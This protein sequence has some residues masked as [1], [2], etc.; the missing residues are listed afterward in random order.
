LFAGPVLSVSQPS[1]WATL[2]IMPQVAAFKGKT[3]NSNLDLTEFE[4]FET[5]LIFSFHL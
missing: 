3:N 4:K 5:R 1:W 2:T